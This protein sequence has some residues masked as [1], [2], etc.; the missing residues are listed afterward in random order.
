MPRHATLSLLL[1]AGCT[2]LAQADDIILRVA[3]KPPQVWV[4]QRVTLEVEVLA[5]GGWAQIP[6]FGELRLPGA[7]VLPMQGQGTRLQETIDGTGYTGQG[8]QLSV[9]PQRAGEIAIPAM[10][11]EVRVKTWGADASETVHQKRTPDLIINV[12]RPPGT[13]GIADLISTTELRA[14]QQWSLDGTTFQ[15]GDAVQR[16]VTRT[17]N[18]VSGMAIAPL[19]VP[20]LPGVGIYPAE[21]R[22]DDAVDRGGLIGRRTD[23]LTYV[24]E[25]AGTVSIPDIEVIWWNIGAERLETATLPGLKAEVLPA[26]GATAGASASTGHPERSPVLWVLAAIVLTGAL[27]LRLAPTLKKRWRAWARSRMDSEARVFRRA[28]A[29]VR[30]RDARRALR[31]IM[32]WLDRCHDGQTPAQLGKVIRRYATQSGLDQVHGLQQSAADGRLLD[33]PEAV[34]K[35]LR[36]V[37]QRRRSAQRNAA[38]AC[39]LPGLNRSCLDT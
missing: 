30:S 29:S 39:V 27:L 10:P 35:Q 22:V 15:I 17:A 5:A 18:E 16:E 26:P 7:Y 38:E 36:I 25:R 34:I 6:T 32:R 2:A 24:F 8:Y 33:D 3:A 37:R 14:A 20:A 12:T 11:V 1:L 23:T 21:P 31:D 19:G 4:G 28:I 13:D 9:Y